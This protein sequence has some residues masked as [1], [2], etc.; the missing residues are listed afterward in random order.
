MSGKV[1]SD[2]KVVADHLNP[3][4]T[5]VAKNLVDKLPGHSGLFNEEQ[6]QRHYSQKGIKLGAFSFR[7]VSVSEVQKRLQELNPCKA[8]GLDNIQ[9]RFVRDSAEVIAPFIT[10]IINLSIE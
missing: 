10:H 1:T 6:V 5:T 3:Y 4:F 9:A 8:A 2:K 7:K